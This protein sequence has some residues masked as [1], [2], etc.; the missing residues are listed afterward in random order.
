MA[1][2]R[3]FSLQLIKLLPFAHGY[4]FFSIFAFLKIRDD[5]IGVP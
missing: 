1:L 3:C 4:L 5:S 2:C